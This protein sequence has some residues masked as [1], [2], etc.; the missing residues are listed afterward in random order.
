MSFRYGGP[1]GRSYTLDRDDVPTGRF[2]RILFCENGR[3]H[4]GFVIWR[5]DVHRRTG[6]EQEGTFGGDLHTESD[7]TLNANGNL[8]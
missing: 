6:D 7:R 1:R 8:Y 3:V 4:S 2:V 5:S